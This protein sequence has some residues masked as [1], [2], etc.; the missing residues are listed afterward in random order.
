MKGKLFKRIL[1]IVGIVIGL[2][3][4]TAILVPILF[5]DKIMTL[6]KKEMNDQ[7][8]A[9][10]DFKDVNISLFRHFPNLAVGI[11]D[12]SI[13]NKA[14]F[15]GDTLI[16]AIRI[17]VS[18][19]L[20]KAISGSYD[21]KS[22]DVETPRIHALVNEKGASNWDITKPDN[23]PKSAAAP[24][25]FALKL[26]HYA[27]SN[28]YFEY[29]D[30]QGKMLAILENLNHSGSG[31]FSSD[32]FKLSTKTSIDAMSYSYGNVPY[33]YKVKT[34]VDLDLDIDNKTGKYSFNT[35]KI[36]LN[37]LR[38]STSG[39]VQ[40][41]DT[42]NMKMDIQ[43]K[44]PSNDFKDILSMVPGI[45]QN[46]FKDIKTSGKAS[47]NGL[48]KGTYN[49]KQMPAY[50]VNLS[51]ENGSFQYPSL[52]EKV[53]NIQIKMQ[54]NNPDGVTDHTIVDIEKGHIEFG[55]EPFDFHLLMKTPISNP[56]VDA[57]MKGKIDLSQMSK[58]MKMEEGTKMAGIINADVSVKGS[59][60]A[61][62][63]QH[64][65]Q[66]DANGSIGIANLMYA[67]KDYPDGV[68][69]YSLMLVFN[70]KNVTVS[71]MKGQYMKTIFSGDGSIDNLL[72]YY[73]HNES[74]TGSL[75]VAA[76]KIDVNKWMG[77]PSTTTPAKTAST[78]PFLVPSNLNITLLAAAG[79]IQYDNLTLTDVQGALAISDQTVNMQNISG[80]G[81]DGTI[82]IS[83]S[84]STKLDKKNPDIHLSYDVSSLDVQKTYTTFNTVQ[85]LMP[86]AKCISG[87]LTST[88]TMQGKLDANMMPVMNSLSGK[89]ELLILQG[90]LNNFP[91][92]DQIADKLKMSQLKSLQL[93][94]LKTYFTFENG[95][96]STTPFTYKVGDISMEVAG[97]HGFDQTIQYG[98]NMAVPRTSLGSQGNAM[99]KDLASKA[100][101]KG[102]P[103][104][105]GDKVN[106][107]IKVGGTITKPTVE[108]D[109]KDVAG[110]AV[111][112][113]KE[114]IA[115][116]AK[117]RVDSARSVVKDTVKAI[118]NQVVKE[119]KNEIK[120]QILGSKDSSKKNDVI[121][122]VKSKAE[123]TLKGLFK[124]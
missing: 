15:A 7:L 45:Y 100:A 48:I 38:M 1:K 11:E 88:L 25:P 22:I 83:G 124:K 117:K 40:M 57:S 75:H 19:D 103:I 39:Y 77:T 93:K 122:D 35:D 49:S 114:Q 111:N 21:I 98:I 91:A 12:L 104:K 107:A 16:A 123:N 84:Y 115:A 108:T 56:W 110:N 105:I 47:L 59:I 41:P 30:D 32:A 86:I 29:R 71:N 80:K 99:V 95:R 13:V 4:L 10:A 102:I 72:G 113:V 89:G 76:D 121:K 3:L 116:E 70:P 119:A 26:R 54:A 68:N 79:T 14:P 33:M 31:D 69:I 78:G 50:T 65:D 87:K 97:S 24:K 106:M 18:V 23:T 20:L 53:S 112:S 46:N 73:L 43:F 51:V 120:N 64:Y 58:F 66:L 92:V 67:S 44:T 118:K 63:Q 55:A 85:M 96:V 36:Q 81:L 82:K 17:D 42:V 6:V 8:N 109:L 62:S 90:T 2:F 28:A 9:T 74:L 34:A 61:A 5:K 27:I 94:D 60:S 52:P 101:G 37:G